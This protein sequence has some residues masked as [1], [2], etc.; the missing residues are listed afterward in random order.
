MTARLDHIVIAAPDLAAL[1]GWFAVRTGVVAQPGGRHPTGTQN[2]LVALTVGGQCGPQYIEL[3]GPYDAAGDAPRPTMFGIDRLT[4]PAV[5]TFAVHPVDIDRAVHDALAVGWETGPARE[6]SRSTPEGELLQWRLTQ[7]REVPARLDVPFLID[8]GATRH[9]GE[10]VAPALELVEFA[11]LEP[12]AERAEALRRE[13]AAVGAEHI[14]VR[15]AERAG[16]LLKLRT[17]AGEV[18]EFRPEPG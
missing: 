6:L 9:P 14:D 16:Y 2:A 12:T 18:V 11:R 7:Q 1:V 4:G 17:A 3:I 13:Y 8:W 15:V 10:T 5:Q